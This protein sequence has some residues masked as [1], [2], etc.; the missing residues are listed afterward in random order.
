MLKRQQLGRYLQ[1]A[2]GHCGLNYFAHLSK[3]PDDEEAPPPLCDLCNED[4]Q[5]SA[6]VLGACPAFFHLR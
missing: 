4:D 6:H 3:D 5:T 1:L 2:T